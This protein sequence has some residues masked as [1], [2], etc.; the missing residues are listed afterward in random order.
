MSTVNNC[1]YFLPSGFNEARL[2]II[3]AGS[4][5]PYANLKTYSS[6]TYVRFH[7]IKV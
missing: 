1:A 3:K 2:K 4:H 7:I 6:S 5:A